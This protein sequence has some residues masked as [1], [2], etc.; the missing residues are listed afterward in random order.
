M[1][2]E[3]A[4]QVATQVYVLKSRKYPAGQAIQLLADD[5]AHIKH[6]ELQAI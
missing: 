2:K 4:G 3:L 5:V 1:A 6:E